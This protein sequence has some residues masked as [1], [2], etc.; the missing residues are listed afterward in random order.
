MIYRRRMATIDDLTIKRRGN[1]DFLSQ[2]FFSEDDCSVF[3]ATCIAYA[4]MGFGLEQPQFRHMCHRAARAR[5]E[6]D[7]KE[8]R[9]DSWIDKLNSQGGDVP[10]VSDSFYRR[11]LC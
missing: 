11:F 3:A 9:R 7:V 4:R 1:P 5:L 2:S 6:E 10:D 8:G